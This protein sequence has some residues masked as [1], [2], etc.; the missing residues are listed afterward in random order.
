MSSKKHIVHVVYCGG[1]GYRPRYEAVKRAIESKFPGV[2]DVVGE[3]TPTTT[4]ALEVELRSGEKTVVL[5]TKLKGEGY[6]DAK[7]M[8][9]IL[10]RLGEFLKSA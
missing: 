8:E 7:K 10:T 1:W 4:G 9:H 6:I 3:A 2:F 5:H